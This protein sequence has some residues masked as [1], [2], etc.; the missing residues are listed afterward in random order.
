MLTEEERAE[1]ADMAERDEWD[2]E[3]WEILE[4]S[5]TVTV[6]IELSPRELVELDRRARAHG[7]TRSQYLRELAT[8]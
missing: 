2:P 6:Q 3:E 8:V 4:S 1:F 7:K 5:K